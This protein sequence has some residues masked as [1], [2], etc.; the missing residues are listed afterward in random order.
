MDSLD[1]LRR[2]LRL[3]L[4]PARHAKANEA[5]ALQ[6]DIPGQRALVAVAGVDKNRLEVS[7]DHLVQDLF[8]GSLRAYVGCVPG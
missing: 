5:S 8:S 1:I 4:P 3:S 2:M 6:L 7:A